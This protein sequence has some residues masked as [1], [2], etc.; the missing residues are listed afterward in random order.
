MKRS[1]EDICDTRASDAN[2][3]SAES[4]RRPMKIGDRS[5]RM[6]FAAR[7][8][9]RS[10][11]PPARLNCEAHFAPRATLMSAQP[12]SPRALAIKVMLFKRDKLVCTQL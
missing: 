1:E 3:S 9:Y 8:V 5:G 4:Y 12:G 7:T 6:C 11:S 10:L 2:V